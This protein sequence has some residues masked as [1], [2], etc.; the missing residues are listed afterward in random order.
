M[1][2]FRGEAASV[3]RNL[4]CMM[5]VVPFGRTGDPEEHEAR[6]P[7]DETAYLCHVEW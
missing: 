5:E 7:L 4:V 3:G 6:F 2:F 1:F